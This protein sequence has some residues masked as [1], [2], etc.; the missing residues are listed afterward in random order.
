MAD[1]LMKLLG[2]PGSA[3][4]VYGERPHNLDRP[5]VASPTGRHTEY[6]MTRQHPS[7]D[8]VNF[9]TVW[10]GQMLNEDQA[11]DLFLQGRNPAL[12]VYK[13]KKGALNAAR[14]RTKRIDRLRRGKRR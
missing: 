8:W 5:I 2:M 10:Q 12:G 6:S 7:G 9:P 13:T 3:G 14:A 1:N 4:V 11:W